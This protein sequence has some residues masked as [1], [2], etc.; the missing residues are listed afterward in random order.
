M[1]ALD[2][3]PRGNDLAARECEQLTIVEQPNVRT[4]LKRGE[5]NCAGECDDAIHGY[6]PPANILG[7]GAA[8]LGN[9]REE[10]A[11]NDIEHQNHVSDVNDL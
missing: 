5:N 8:W 10:E 1:I 9:L 3:Q 7:Q 11:A 6:P 2:G 4:H